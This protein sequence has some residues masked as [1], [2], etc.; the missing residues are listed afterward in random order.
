MWI[1][2]LLA[3]GLTAGT[4]AR[5]THCDLPGNDLGG[6]GGGPSAEVDPEACEKRCAGLAGCEAYV[7]I[8][9]WKRC[10]PKTKAGTKVPV[11]YFSGE[12]AGRAVD[13]AALDRDYSGKDLRR[14]VQVKSG[15]DCGKECSAEP[16]CKA[17]AYIG[18]YADCW[19]KKERG[20]PKP[21]VFSCGVKNH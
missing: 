2:L 9:G 18:G 21:K 13:D 11:R 14:V 10:F 8:S 7:F 17:F 6:K 5:E 16:Q 19:L 12:M 1:P 4:F 20:N 15:E 3:L